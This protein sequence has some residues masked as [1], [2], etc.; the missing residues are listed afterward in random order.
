MDVDIEKLKELSVNE[1]RERFNIT[2]QAAS[3]LRH[4][5]EHYE[6]LSNNSLSL[7][8]MADIDNIERY[9]AKSWRYALIE[10]GLVEKELRNGVERIKKLSKIKNNKG[11]LYW[12]I[13]LS[14][15]ELKTANLNPEKN[16]FLI[17]E[18]TNKEL[19][20]KIFDD[21]STAFDYKKQKLQ[22]QVT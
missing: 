15:K 2:Q 9:Q 16:Y 7:S 12:Y 22:A 3:L 5:L 1:L 6:M 10:S 4:G 8:E 14:E 17:V 20:V 18:P 11:K 19:K 13:N 21:Y